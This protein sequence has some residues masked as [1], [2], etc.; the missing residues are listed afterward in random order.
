[1]PKTSRRSVRSAKPSKTICGECELEVKEER[2]D[3]IQCDKCAKI[4]H[5]LCTKL[6]KRQYDQLC[7]NEEEEFECH[8][9]VGNDNTVRSELLE[10]KTKLSKLNKL[11]QL[12]ELQES[13][14]FM[15][16]KFD[17]VL[18]GMLENK[19]KIK[20]IEK[21]NRVLKTE[22][23]NLKYSVKILNDQRVKNDCLISGIKNVHN[24]NAVET[25][26]EMSK[27]VGVDISEEQIDEAYFLKRMNEEQSGQ[28]VVVK[29]N[30]KSAKTKLMIAKPKLKDSDTTKSIYINDFLSKESLELLKYARSLKSVGYHAVYSHGGKIYAR[31][32]AITRPRIIR[33]EDDVNKILLEAATNQ[34]R[35]KIIT[36]DV[37]DGSEDGDEND[38]ISPS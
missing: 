2:E 25:V 3:N 15:S 6:N 30:S 32:S 33:D 34:N 26:I 29:F 5:A 38:F 27:K 9:C 31:K 1:M 10:I 16:S 7:E 12:A 24:L 18:K 13:V 23:Q 8:K 20:N 35:R 36:A 14:N 37:S 21:E 11:D 4:F 28:A 22:V 19:E 17:Q